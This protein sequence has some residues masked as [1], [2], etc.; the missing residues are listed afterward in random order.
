VIDRYIDESKKI[1]RTKAQVLR[2]IQ[3][4]D[5]ADL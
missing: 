1:G 5:I 3:T 2:T 4:Y